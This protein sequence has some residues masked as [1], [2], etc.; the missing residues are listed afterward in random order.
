[1]KFKVEQL[2]IKDFKEFYKFVKDFILK[3]FL[4]YPPRIRRF[5]LKKNLNQDSLKKAL[6]TKEKVILVA[7]SEEKI[8]GFILIAFDRG[9]GTHCSWFGVDENFRNHGVGSRL[10]R[11]IEKLA[12]RR[13]CHF[14]YFWT[15]NR[16]N[17]KFYQKRGYYLVGLQ[18][19]SW[20]GMDEYLMQKNIG[21]PVSKQWK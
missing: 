18:K 5:Y 12:Q 19:E 7:R 3:Q 15:E 16:N 17:I 13:K 10:M 8:I 9:G 14:I 6:K 20:Y 1:M 11:E 2:K 4:D 21:K